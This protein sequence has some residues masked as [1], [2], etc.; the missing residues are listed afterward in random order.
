[1]TC[2]VLP[3][4]ILSA[5]G[6]SLTHRYVSRICYTVGVHV[7]RVQKGSERACLIRRMLQ[8][9][10]L[11]TLGM[12]RVAAAIQVHGMGLADNAVNVTYQFLARK[13][14][15]LS[16][17]STAPSTGAALLSQNVLL[18]YSSHQE[19]SRML[20][21]LR[22]IFLPCR[23]GRGSVPPAHAPLLCQMPL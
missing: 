13:V 7:L 6:G 14:T 18:S 15:M 12:D 1:M 19:L 3:K 4:A 11:R 23:L 17:V 22:N 8:V 10:H 5:H 21:Y 9:K 2:L 20:L 16:Q